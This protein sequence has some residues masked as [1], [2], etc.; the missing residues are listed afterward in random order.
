L[1]LSEEEIQMPRVLRVA[2]SVLAAAALATTASPQTPGS[3][4]LDKQVDQIFS[5]FT[6]DVPGCAVAVYQNGKVLLAKGYGSANLEYGVP[7]TPATPFI[8][9]S[10]AKQFTAAAIA[11]LVEEKR[12]ALTDDVRKYVPELADYGT[13]ITIDHLVHHTSGL[14]DWWELVGLAG[15]RFDDTYAVQDVLDMTA[16]QHGLNFTPGERYVYSNTGYI[17]LGIVVQ[18]VTGK[19][20]REFAAERIFG[21]LKMA[22]S[23]YQDD[24]TQ[25]VRGRAY[26]YSPTAGGRYTINVWNNDLVGQ[27]GVMTTVLDLAKWDANFDTGSVGGRGFLQRQLQQGTL[28]SGAQLDYAFGLQVGRYR[29]LDLIEHSGSTGGYRAV[30]SRFPK[31]RTSIAALCNISNAAPVTLA[32]RVADYLL[33]DSFT[34]PVPTTSGASA[35]TTGANET[36]PGSTAAPGAHVTPASL[37][38]FAGSYFSDELGAIY[39]ITV[40]GSE[41]TVRRPRGK[42]ESLTPR[43]AV[44]FETAAIGRLNF[45]LGP[46][47]RAER[48]VLD[49]GRVQNITF[50]RR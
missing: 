26:A 44:T 34:A 5:A 13:P 46:D 10:V 47:G 29:G 20:L 8:I 38:Q 32:H 48:F 49:A 41:L 19:S 6:P 50:V 22:S 35:A 15:M 16:R 33:R 45:T 37:G 27:G 3:P 2:L 36:R 42:P 23:H 14:R 4:G 39:E 11:L 40:S 30:L 1:F 18:R 28:N 31:Q 17:V 21:P 24:H 12:I 25:P 7:I 9:G 43:D